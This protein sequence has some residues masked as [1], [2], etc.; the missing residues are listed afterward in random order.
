M[1]Q[2]SE[3]Y[4]ECRYLQTENV[5]R[6]QDTSSGLIVFSKKTVCSEK[7]VHNIRDIS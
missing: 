2:L 1:A 7:Q 3:L 4:F 6:R 5:P